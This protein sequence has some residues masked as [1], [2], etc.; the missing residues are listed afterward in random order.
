[1]NAKEQDISLAVVYTSPGRNWPNKQMS[2]YLLLVWDKQD[3]ELIQFKTRSVRPINDD[4]V[5]ILKLN[6][7]IGDFWCDKNYLPDIRQS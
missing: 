3:T 5:F 4:N 7:K 2:R 6:D 1:M